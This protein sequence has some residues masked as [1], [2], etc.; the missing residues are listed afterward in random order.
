MENS[1]KNIVFSGTFLSVNDNVI[2]IDDFKK[3]IPEDTYT[4]TENKRVHIYKYI[5]TENHLKI[6]FGDG[7]AMPRNPNVFDV[8]TKTTLP[9]PRQPNQAEPKETFGLIDFNTGFLW[10]SNSRK[11][12]SLIDFFRTKFDNKTK[13]VSKD[14]YDEEKFIETLK[15]LDDI[16]LSAVPNLLS[17]SNVLTEKLAEE[18]NGFEATSAQLHF[19][20]QDKLIGNSLLEKIKSIFENRVNF[21]G[22]VISGRDENNLGMLFNSDGFSRKIE[23]KTTVDENEM[24]LPDDVF[25]KLLSKIRNEDI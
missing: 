17:Q 16:R 10:L 12:N 7:S 13:L 5:Y 14:V 18:I 6:T 11:R 22:V 15:K 2:N 21:N 23:F 9:N 1:T 25:T 20:Y 3:Q 19:H 24:F 4:I 8:E